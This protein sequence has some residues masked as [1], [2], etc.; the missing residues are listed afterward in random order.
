MSEQR[1]KNELRGSQNDPDFDLDSYLD[2][3][4]Q[5]EQEKIEPDKKQSTLSAFL[6]NSFLVIGLATFALLYFNDWSPKK[7]YANIFGVEEFQSQPIPSP[8]SNDVV[9]PIAPIEGNDVIVIDKDDLVN[10]TAN[11]VG[12]EDLAIFESLE[13][14]ES[15]EALEDLASLEGLAD[16][17]K[18]A[19]LGDL[20]NL[21]NV[22]VIPSDGD[23]NS[24]FPSS[25]TN[26]TNELSE[27]GISD[28]YEKETIQQLYQA[29]VPVKVL[30]TLNNLN[31]LDTID[32][33]SLI[34][35]YK[36]KEN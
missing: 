3:K 14:L 15:L 36:I 28:K 34:E 5:S 12:L 31:L 32:I 17:S 2:E 7:I 26:Y 20:G 9:L 1:F 25:L 35:G 6:K 11:I 4:S 8:V 16:L 18:L 29:K 13:S 33:S 21:G 22:K 24:V 10:G 19:A 27:A 23:Q 30:S